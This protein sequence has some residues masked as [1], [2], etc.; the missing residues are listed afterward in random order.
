MCRLCWLFLLAVSPGLSAESLRAVVS[1]TN[2]PPFVMSKEDQL[3]GG[4]VLD[5]VAEVAKQLQLPLEVDAIPRG[6][7]EA[8]LNSGQADIW[9]FTN[10]AWVKDPQTLIWSDVMYSNIELLVRLES[11]HPINT[12]LDLHGKTI[13]TSRGFRYP[14]LDPVFAAG[15]ARRDDAIS[16]SQN[17][18][19]LKQVRVD[20]V[21]ADSITFNYYLKSSQQT[22]SAVPIVA[23]PMWTAA[24]NNYCAVS[25]QDPQKAQLILQALT[26]IAEQQM[27]SWLA[28]YQ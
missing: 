8:W 12:V 27:T 10:P 11:S 9:C 23:D 25:S 5:T 19:R 21:V 4:L 24:I 28:A 16:L 2:I 20:V 1:E 26:R 3:S 6:R 17:L 13:G 22:E 18:Q 7:T 15:F 14:E